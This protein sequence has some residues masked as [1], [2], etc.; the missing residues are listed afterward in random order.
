MLVYSI[1]ISVPLCLHVFVFIRVCVSLCV[2]VSLGERLCICV[3]V[4]MCMC[5]VMCMCAGCTISIP[6][7]TCL[8][9]YRGARLCTESHPSIHPSVHHSFILQL[10]ATGSV[11]PR[12]PRS[13]FPGNLREMQFFRP[14]PRLSE[15]D[16]VG[17]TQE[18]PQENFGL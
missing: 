4:H 13:A 9:F 1:H 11:A 10:L 14:H 15:S 18:T 17:E 12:A 2:S 8:N 7:K 5:V 6:S 3:S 16:S